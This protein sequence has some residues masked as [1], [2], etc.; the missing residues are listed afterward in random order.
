CHSLRH[1]VGGRKD[2]ISKSAVTDAC[3]S[4]TTSLNN[5]HQL[6]AWCSL[7]SVML[8]DLYIRL[9]SMGYLSDPRLL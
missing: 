8:T 1:I 9:C 6:F 5:R 3:Y 4:C 7:F 2:E